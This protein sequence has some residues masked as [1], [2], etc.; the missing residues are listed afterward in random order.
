MI[1]EASLRERIHTITSQQIQL[2]VKDLIFVVKQ[3]FKVPCKGDNR[4]L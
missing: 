1:D 3:K 2:A 4:N